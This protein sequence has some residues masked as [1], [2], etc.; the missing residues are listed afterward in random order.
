MVKRLKDFSSNAARLRG[1]VE[2]LRKATRPLE[3]VEGNI[4]RGIGCV[5]ALSALVLNVRRLQDQHIA[6]SSKA[7][8][9]R[10]TRDCV[11]ACKEAWS[12]LQVAGKHPKLVVVRKGMKDAFA[13]IAVNCRS[14]FKAAQQAVAKEHGQHVDKE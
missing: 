4:V 14:E 6:T 7:E 13:T 3:L 1:Y 12:K 11:A 8:Y 10:Q 9:Y 2:E 5:E